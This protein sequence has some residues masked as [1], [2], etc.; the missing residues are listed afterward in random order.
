MD[1][2]QII[3]L[4]KCT[5]GEKISMVKIAVYVVLET[6]LGKT[7]L[8]KANSIPELIWN[9]LSTILKKIWGLIW[10]KNENKIN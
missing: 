9:I 8:V 5:P 7:N 3:N 6:F 4:A 1:F 2:G 10:S